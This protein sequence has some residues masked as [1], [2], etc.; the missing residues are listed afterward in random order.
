MGL[1]DVIIP[2]YNRAD[3]LE[4][5]IRSVLHQSYQDFLIT[6]VDDGSNDNTNE[7]LVNLKIELGKKFQFFKTE[8]NGVSAAR[9]FAVSQ[10]QARWICFLDSDD[11]WLTNKLEEQVE[12]A[13]HS[14]APLIHGEEIWIRNGA[15]VNQMKKHQKYG[16]WILEHCLEMCKISPS[17]VMIRRDVFEEFGGF[18]EDFPVCEDYDLWLKICSKYPCEYIKEPIIK[19]YGGHLD[20]LSRKYFAMDYWRIQ[21][22]KSLLQS[23]SNLSLDL[24]LKAKEVLERKCN[25]LIQGYRKHNNWKNYSEVQSI[26]DWV[27]EL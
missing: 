9:N 20:Q 25:I 8:N 21:S 27:A 18:R 11:E 4:R 7:I 17:A 10:T 22:L 3:S 1:I 2:T 13:M 19:K 16:G 14:T 24:K 15:R 23:E 6:V 5:A 12:I 26:L